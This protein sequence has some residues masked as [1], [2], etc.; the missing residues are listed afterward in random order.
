MSTLTFWDAVNAILTK[1]EKGTV[2]KTMEAAAMGSTLMKKLE[3]NGAPAPPSFKVGDWVRV[4]CV[5]KWRG[6]VLRIAEQSY[7]YWAVR[8]GD[9]FLPD[10]LEPWVP[11]PGERVRCILPPRVG[12]ELTV[13]ESEPCDPRYVEPVVDDKCRPVIARVTRPM[14]A[15]A[16]NIR[17]ESRPPSTG[18][19][20]QS[21]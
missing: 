1:I 14:I 21:R 5:G 3:A 7:P 6:M 17:P 11:R 4:R 8:S 20:R 16:R 13:T 10:E 15:V 19:P 18:T 12:H 9:Y 2:E